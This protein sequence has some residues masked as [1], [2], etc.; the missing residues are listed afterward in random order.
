MEKFLEAFV[1]EFHIVDGL[2][3][4]NIIEVLGFVEDLQNKVAWIVSP[5]KANGNVREFLRSG[6]W[7]IPERISLIKDVSAG[8][9][10]LHGRQPPICH[11]DLK[12]LNILVS[13]LHRAVIT[14]FGSARVMKNESGKSNE[15]DS[16]ST[17][18]GRVG[19][20]VDSSLEA[21]LSDS[22]MTLTLTGPSVSFRWAS[23]ELMGGKY[24]DLASDVWA[25]G[26]ICWEI[27]TDDYPFPE[28]STLPGLVVRVV[29]GQLPQIRE[30]AQLSQIRE[31][32][33]V[34]N[35]CWKLGPETRPTAR[36]CQIV[37]EG[38]PSVVPISRDGGSKIR[39]ATLILGLGEV[40]QRGSRYDEAS[41]ALNEGLAIARATG[42]ERSM[43]SALRAIGALQFDLSKYDE[44]KEYLNEALV[45][46]KRIGDAWGEA[47]AL[48]QLGHAHQ[49]QCQYPEA[50]QHINQAMA[51]YTNIGDIWGQYGA[52]FALGKIYSARSKYE[53]AEDS[54]AR[55]LELCESVGTDVDYANVFFALGG[56]YRAQSKLET[57]EELYA[58]AFAL[59]E[60]IGHDMNRANALCA[61]GDIQR[62]TNRF[63]DAK[64]SLTEALHVSKT[65]GN[66]M[67]LAITLAGLGEL[68]ESQS[69][70]EDAE[71]L[72]NQA[73]EIY[74]RKDND[75][76]RACILCSL[77]RL[78][79]TRAKYSEAEGP[80]TTA[81]EL[82]T[83]FEREEGQ[84]V[85]SFLLG[86]LRFHQARYGEAKA[87][88]ANA[89]WIASG[90]D[91]EGGMRQAG[92]LLDQVLEAEEMHSKL[93]PSDLGL[94]LSQGP[95]K[96]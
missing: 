87:F 22:D 64:Q 85:T 74:K 16:Q 83:R 29:Q 13:S 95:S 63:E 15:A 48:R 71:T 24:P 93:P 5:W 52:W 55:A 37:L 10:Y 14:D 56:I 18:A 4:P 38:L 30:D 35:S 75:W 39:S 73:M 70:L 54:F 61:L 49:A 34:M 26:W 33:K 6:D 23:P 27:M 58:Q 41:T 11:G 59:Y 79:L 20:N 69:D 44:A 81:L 51:I 12:S 19:S 57:A 43:G 53:L 21:V 47:D 78:H 32:C 76:G 67:S 45:L 65:L 8:L 77:G 68:N 90:L 25:L 89:S 96:T 40:F 42:D 94:G 92:E 80:L 91:D 84:L 66:D 82:F 7:E 3:H 9:D 31:L 1:N 88:I 46:F 50:E 62:T 60:S 86:R 17:P 2:S 72:Y 36:G 28:I